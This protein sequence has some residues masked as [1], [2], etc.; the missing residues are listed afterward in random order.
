MFYTNEA[1]FCRPFRSITELVC[2]MTPRRDVARLPAAPNLK[3]SKPDTDAC[4]VARYLRRLQH[5]PGPWN[6]PSPHPPKA[7]QPC[8]QVRQSS[9]ASC[10]KRLFIFGCVRM[11]M[12]IYAAKPAGIPQT[13]T[14]SLW[15]KVGDGYLLL[16]ASL[17]L[18]KCPL[19]PLAL[20]CSC[21]RHT[22]SVMVS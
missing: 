11:Q 19:L 15:G 6:G 5:R 18:L 8:C 13:R 1:A 3:N 2:A 22:H 21:K 17:S 20:T 4:H 7:S 14:S 12:L 9:R 16:G 10:F